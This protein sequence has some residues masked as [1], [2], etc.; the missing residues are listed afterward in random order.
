[1]ST[2]NS[3]LWRGQPLWLHGAGRRPQQIHRALRGP[4]RSDVVI[5]G[6]G[7]TGALI[8]CVFADAGVN[9]TLLEAARVGRGSTSASSALLLQ[10]PDRGMGELARRYGLPASKRI[11]TLS[12]D[13]VRD[14]VALVR[15]KRIACD[16]LRADAI[17]F[18]PTMEAAAQLDDEFRLRVRAGFNAEWLTPGPLRRA[19]G[20]A[21]FGAIRTPGNAQ[22]DPYKACC[23]LIDAA[24]SS[25]AQVFE[26]SAVR[27]I[28]QRRS[29]VRVHTAEGYVDAARVVI[30]TGY[31]TA[32]F[33]PLAGRFRLYRTYVLATPIVNPRQ[34]RELGLGKVMLWDTER[35]YHYGRWS[36]DRRLLLGGGDRPIVAGQTR[37]AEYSRARRDLGDYFY[38]LF[39]ALADIGIERTWEGLFA[40]TADGLPYIGPHR[41]Y[42]HHS[43]ALGYGGN[44]MTF[45]FLAARMLLEQWRGIASPDHRLFRFSR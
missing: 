25:G 36:P 35:P 41:A 3:Q 30:A 23:G 33:R 22:F 39:P 27:R 5:V 13:A 9:I 8:A 17:Y 10:E 31:A 14:F 1:M 4:R 32:Y 18:A 44:G 40:M 6:G 15:H 19:C 45:G 20:I 43:F 2:S 42:P 24:V 26:R 37:Q 7:M 38:R 34:R 11:W 21:G 12:R 28:D 29:G 16:L